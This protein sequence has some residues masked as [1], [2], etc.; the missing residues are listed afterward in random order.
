MLPFG[1]QGSNSAIEDGGAL[2]YLL[3][4]VNNSAAIPERLRIF[5][6]VRQARAARVQILSSV[7]AGK[8]SEVG[9]LL[10]P[11]ADPAENGELT[12]GTL[13]DANWGN[14][15]KLL[16]VPTSM[17]ERTIHDYG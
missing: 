16:G 4:G 2:G 12:M 17:I 3:Q 6:E 15:D 7:R 5:Q 10:K 8:E 13:P 9:D 1:G 14:I 11:H